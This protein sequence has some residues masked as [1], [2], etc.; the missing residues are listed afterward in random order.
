M[1]NNIKKQVNFL[2]LVYISIFIIV[3]LSQFIYLLIHNYPRELRENVLIKYAVDFAHGINPYSI[4]M[5]NSDLPH[6][7]S[8]YGFIPALIIAPFV[9]MVGYE[10]LYT[11]VRLLFFG[12]KI[13]GIF[14]FFLVLKNKGY[15]KNIS[16]IGAFVYFLTYYFWGWNYYCIFPNTIAL[17]LQALLLFFIYSDDNKKNYHPLI[18]SVISVI[19][20]YCKQYFVLIACPIFIYFLIN[21]MRVAIKYFTYTF[22]IFFVSIF[23]V[24]KVFPL[25]FTLAIGWIKVCCP[26]NGIRYLIS[27]LYSIVKSGFFILIIFFFMRLY[28]EIK[29]TI[30]IKGRK[31]SNTILLVKEKV[32]FELLTVF[33]LFLPTCYL[34]LNG[35]QF[36]EYIL[37]IIVP[38]FSI[39]AL[40]IFDIVFKNNNRVIKKTISLLVTLCLLLLSIPKIVNP[41]SARNMKTLND[42]NTVFSYID[43]FNDNIILPQHLSYYCIKNSIYTDDYGQNEYFLESHKKDLDEIGYWKT[44]FPNLEK[45]YEI[46]INYKNVVNTNIKNELYDLVVVTDAGVNNRSNTILEGANYA[47]DFEI[48][49]RCGNQIWK[50]YFYRKVN[51]EKVLE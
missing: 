25:Y 5:L 47:L 4:E 22:L 38:F 27:Q 26:L 35:G 46:Q 30:C 6:N 10:N 11:F 44:L 16:I 1:Q 40:G 2:F 43:D 34:S 23:L 36:C 20:F 9:K 24:N 48:P 13:V 7:H 14:L 33:T 42:W 28:L 15:T 51:N 37:Q 29:E 31:I 18:Y 17:T 21:N 8:G 39:Y 3:L 45:L 12:I 32:S 50:T 49:L 41:F 19:L